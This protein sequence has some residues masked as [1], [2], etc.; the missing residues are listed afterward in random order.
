[1]I[2]ALNTLKDKYQQYKDAFN[3]LT[4]ARKATQKVTGKSTLD[5]VDPT[6]KFKPIEKIEQDLTQA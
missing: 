5:F 4:P 3:P 2:Q 1:M 6:F